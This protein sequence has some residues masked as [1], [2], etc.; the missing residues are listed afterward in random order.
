L[1]SVNDIPQR[2]TQNFGMSLAASEQY[3]AVKADNSDGDHVHVYDMT[4]AYLFEVDND[5]GVTNTH[6]FGR[7]MRIVGDTLLVGDFL[8]NNGQGAIHA[9]DRANN[10]AL[11][12][13]TVSPDQ[14]GAGV[15]FDIED[16]VIVANNRNSDFIEVYDLA[17][18]SFLRRWG[19]AGAANDH[20]EVIDGIVVNGTSADMTF[21]RL[22]NNQFMGTG[23]AVGASGG[24]Q[25]FEEA[26]DVLLINSGVQSAVSMFDPN[27]RKLL[28][29]I[30]FP[31]RL[32]AS[33]PAFGS[34]ME[35]QGG[36]VLIGAPSHES[37]SGVRG[38]GAAYII[39][40]P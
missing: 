7:K 32:G 25:A 12:W 17:S 15:D 37:E 28:G 33:L 35:Y 20:L 10:G 31:D 14:G 19:Q 24:R 40:M 2:D 6:S 18:G 38:T 34:S 27:T 1:F 29:R 11:K 16:D 26:E 23:S 9:F 22:S 5:A 21:A 30:E 4:G 36:Q 39:D 3:L 8:A 13:S